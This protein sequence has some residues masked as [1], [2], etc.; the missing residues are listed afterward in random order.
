MSGAR[1]T[2]RVGGPRVGAGGSS[3]SSSATWGATPKRRHSYSTASFE[4]NGGPN[5]RGFFA[6]WDRGLSQI[7]K[8]LHEEACQMGDERHHLGKQRIRSSYNSAGKMLSGAGS[9]SAAAGAVGTGGGA[10]TSSS[11]S[12]GVSDGVPSSSS[13]S[14]AHQ[15]KQN[16]KY[17]AG[18]V[19][20]EIY[21]NVVKTNYAHCRPQSNT[22]GASEYRE[23]WREHDEAFRAFQDG[24]GAGGAEDGELVSFEA[25]PWPPV[26]GDIL[27]FCEALWSPGHPKQAYRIACR[28]WHPDKFLALYGHRLRPADKDRVQAKVNEIFQDITNSKKPC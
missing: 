14:S 7:R 21:E 2:T 5:V 27:E 18:M 10:T 17:F 19:D 28:R 3:S 6:Q 25:I 16:N 22:L 24:E 12:S 8:D 1:Y 26:N 9:A 20:D 13:S 23:I 4:P 11:G 15:S